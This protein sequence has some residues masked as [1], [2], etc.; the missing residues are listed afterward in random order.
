M[1]ACSQDDTRPSSAAER[2]MRPASSGRA[3]NASRGGSTKLIH[4]L[5]SAAPAAGEHGAGCRPPSAPQAHARRQQAAL[6]GSRAPQR[7]M[8][9]LLGGGGSHTRS[10]PSSS[11]SCSCSTSGCLDRLAATPSA[12]EAALAAAARRSGSIACA[13]RPP[14]ACGESAVQSAQPRLGAHRSTS[15]PLPAGHVRARCTGAAEGQQRGAAMPCSPAPC[16]SPAHLHSGRLRQLLLPPAALVAAAAQVFCRVL[17][18]AAVVAAVACIPQARRRRSKSLGPAYSWP[19]PAAVKAAVQ[20]AALVSAWQ[21]LLL[22][23]SGQ[24]PT[25][26]LRVRLPLRLLRPSRHGLEPA[27][28]RLPERRLVRVH[29]GLHSSAHAAA[30]VHLQ[31]G[32]GSGAGYTV[33]LPGLAL[34][35]GNARRLGLQPAPLQR[36]GMVTAAP[37][38]AAS[39]PQTVQTAQHRTLSSSCGHTVPLLP[40]GCCTTLQLLTSGTAAPR[41]RLA[42]CSLPR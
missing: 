26:V 24:A 6:Q 27:V 7:Q 20:A 32:K 41:S 12:R 28:Q 4:I 33:K 29:L 10:V 40:A 9:L 13:S 30:V 34:R 8:Y 1:R 35:A 36:S 5:R 38:P 23:R 19:S 21:L 11:V 14:A 42:S 31:G 18:Q 22:L 25:L 2:S 16:P 39:E 17:L 15:A 3:V 37:D